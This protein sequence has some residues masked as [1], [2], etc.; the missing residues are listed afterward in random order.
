V[1]LGVQG[2][3]GMTQNSGVG[4]ASG[5]FQT[6]SNTASI[7]FIVYNVNATSGAITLLMDDF[8]V[9]PQQVN[10]GPVVTDWQSYTLTIG[11]TTTA[12]TPGTTT[13]NSAK[14]RRVGDTMEITYQFEQTAAGSAG[15]GDYLFPIPTGYS[16][17]TTKLT[18]LNPARTIVG[19]AKISFGLATS[20][21][22]TPNASVLLG[23]TNANAFKLTYP[24]TTIEGTATV[25]SINYGLSAGS[26]SFS[27]FARVPIQ[28][29]SSNVQMSSDSYQGINVLNASTAPATVPVGLINFTGSSIQGPGSY[30]SGLFTVAQ[31]GTYVLSGKGLKSTSVASDIYIQKNGTNIDYFTT[32]TSTGSSASFTLQLNAGDTIG[33]YNNTGSWTPAIAGW[34]AMS[35]QRISGPSVLAASEKVYSIYTGSNGATIPSIT[36]TPIQFLT[37]VKDSN[38]AVSVVGGYTRFTAP[39]SDLYTM[40]FAYR[41]TGG[42]VV[43]GN[44]LAAL[45]RLNGTTTITDENW[46]YRTTT[47]LDSTATSS[48]SYYLNA[49]DYVEFCAYSQHTGTNTVV[50]S[51]VQTF[52]HIE[53][54]GN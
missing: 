53:A 35:L 6:N 17:D 22:T 40:K 14:W 52:M 25:N 5:T 48:I 8:F 27:F 49:G 19:D 28:G 7:R 16:V 26:L 30:S 11:A 47:A 43:V 4:I 32:V 45:I 39:R 51:A 50:T 34:V 23:T 20:G 54:A 41:M 46:S 37:K 42:T 2:A 1:F 29:W 18:A 38:G 3:F 12:P 33:L 21:A 13:V 24:N 44:V 36:T 31:S 9:G 15:S 10:I